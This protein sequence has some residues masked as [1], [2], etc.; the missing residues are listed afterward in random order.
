MV[1]QRSDRRD[2]SASRIRNRHGDALRYTDAE[3]GRKERQVQQAALLDGQAARVRLTGLR[4]R[5]RREFSGWKR[6]LPL[7]VDIEVVIAESRISGGCLG[8]D[9]DV[10]GR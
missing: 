3:C 1:R 9:L 4:Q 2:N 5:V 7:E 6:H 8:G 10:I